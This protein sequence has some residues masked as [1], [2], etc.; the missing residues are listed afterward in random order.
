MVVSGRSPV[1][2]RSGTAIASCL[3]AQAARRSAGLAQVDAILAM[4]PGVQITRFDVAGNAAVERAAASAYGMIAPGRPTIEGIAIQG[5]PQFGFTLDYGSFE[6]VAVGVGAYGPDSPWPGVAIRFV[7]K[8]GGNH[9]RGSLYL[10]YVHRAGRRSTSTKIRRSACRAES[11]FLHERPT[12]CGATATPM[13]TP[14]GRSATTGCGGTCRFAN[15]TWR[16]AR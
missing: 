9:H 5:H 3:E 11:A 15:R 2:D 8:S 14:A 16:R 13:W 4:T 12:A 6:H 10:D 7:T 1:I